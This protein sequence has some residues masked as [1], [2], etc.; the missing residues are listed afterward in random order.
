LGGYFGF[1]ARLL[2]LARNSSLDEDSKDHQEPAREV[3]WP[4]DLLAPDY[5]DT[6]IL[7]Y[8][9]DSRV[10]NFFSGP[11]NQNGILQHG[12]DLL[13]RLAGRRRKA[14]PTRPLIFVVHSLGGLILKEV[15]PIQIYRVH[16]GFVLTCTGI[17]PSKSG[18]R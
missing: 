7:T 18:K 16:C 5:N 4:K 17:M 9:Y 12:R 15:S 8:G 3:F 1:A 13:T 10:A 11:A 2:G 6:R 14:D